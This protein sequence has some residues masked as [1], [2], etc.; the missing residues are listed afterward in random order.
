MTFEFIDNSVAIDRAARRRIRTHAA[1]GK[2]ANKTLAR[3]SKAIAHKKDDS[4][5]PFRTPAS[6]RK[7]YR[8]TSDGSGDAEV[9]EIERP[10]SDGVLFPIPV[11][12]RSKG[13]VRE[14][15]YLAHRIPVHCRENKELTRSTSLK[16]CSSSAALDTTLSLMAR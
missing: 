7:A 5:T 4:A 1:T 15:A 8:S 9:A 12:A 16:L 11:P 3:S 6:I 10:V 2:N 14:G 13:L